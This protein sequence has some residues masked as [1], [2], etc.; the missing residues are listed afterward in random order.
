L[1]PDSQSNETLKLSY[2]AGTRLFDRGFIFGPELGT[3][4]MPRYHFVVCEPDHTH[5]DPDGMHLPNPDAAKDH[6]RR[7]VRELKDGGYCPGNAALVIHDE[8]GQTVQSIPF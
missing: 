7:I 1:F 3:N 6:G 5:D 4:P 8:I 2:C